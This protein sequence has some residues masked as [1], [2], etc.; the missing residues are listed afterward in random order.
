MRATRPQILLGLVAVTL[1]SA[2][3]QSTPPVINDIGNAIERGANDVVGAASGV[4]G[5][6]NMPPPQEGEEEAVT[7][8]RDA[9]DEGKVAYDTSD[10][11]VAVEK[12]TE[13]FAAAEDIT[14][15]QLEAQ[16]QS[17]LHY[18]LG[19]A[20]LKAY[21]LDN[22][23]TRLGKAK[24]ELQKYLDANPELPEEERDEVNALIADADAKASQG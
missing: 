3:C 24:S 17:A 20:H 11:I 4:V 9:Y 10:Y 22:D 2:A 1:A 5:P 14:D 13:S 6:R 8:A 15:P 21:E 19:R 23:A 16:V 7:R 12:F 18:N